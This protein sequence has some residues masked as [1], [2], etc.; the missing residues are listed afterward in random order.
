MTA[1]EQ[2]VRD[3]VTRWLAASKAHDLATVLSLMTDDVVFMTPGQETFGKAAFAAR[4]DA[5]KDV[6]IEGTPN[7]L[8]VQVAGDWAWMRNYLTITLTTPGRPPT[9]RAGHIL[10]IFRKNS[11]G[12]WQIA[13]DANLL[14]FG[15]P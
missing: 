9:T 4:N 14:T 3:V 1:D 7:I 10:T 2:A 5:M 15:T 13:R 8:E 6:Q 12:Q 11:Q